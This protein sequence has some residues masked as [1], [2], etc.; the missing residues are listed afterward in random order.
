MKRIAMIGVAALVAGFLARA[1]YAVRELMAAFVL[2]SAGFAVLALFFG[3]CLLALR[4]TAAIVFW[5]SLRSPQ[6]NRAVR[7]SIFAF[8]QSVR[9][10][11]KQWPQTLTRNEKLF[12]IEPP[13][14][15]VS[16]AI[17]SGEDAGVLV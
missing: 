9:G 17:V 13:P 5:V 6:W 2:F 1:S 12:I 7:E 11:A 16:P 4:A 15:L 14:L 8:R 10:I 3:F